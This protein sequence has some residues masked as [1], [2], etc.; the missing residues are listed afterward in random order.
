MSDV[1]SR[2][3]ALDLVK[4]YLR[5]DKLVK[6]VLAVEAILRAVARELGE[7]EEL[8]GL[9]GLLHDLDYEVVG[10]DLN[11][12][13]LVTPEIIEGKV[14]DEVIEAIKAHNEL[15]GF[16]S[17]SKLAL[18]LKAADHASGLIIATA[19]VMPH[20]KLE[21]VKVESLL[22]KFKQKDFARNVKRER[23]LNCEKIGI[24][25]KEFLEISLRALQSIHKE[26]GL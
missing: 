19:L 16:E 25:L 8:W 11:R 12:H 4:Q 13:G 21:E 5:N 3:E 6:H 23:I 9:T 22:R 10:K 18:A 1:I 7:D 14:P 15:T 20:K 2:G 17:D 26:L 24:P